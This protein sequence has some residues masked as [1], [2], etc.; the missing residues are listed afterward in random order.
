[1]KIKSIPVGEYQVNCFILP[2]EDRRALIID[3]GKDAPDIL[4]LLK[5]EDLEVAAY[6][7]TH[8]HMDHVS[9]VADIYDAMPAPIA[10]HPADATW[11]FLETNQHPP[12]YGPPRPPAVIERELTDGSR[13][14]ESGLAYEIIATPGHTPGGVCIYFPAEQALFTGDTLFAGSVGRTDLPG[15]DSRILQ[16]SLKKLAA[17]PPETKVFPGHGPATSIGHEKQTNFFL[18]RL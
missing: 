4:K 18:S 11:A 15:G 17:L 8:G 13:W 5:D 16:E 7:L 12:F 9:A 6:L 1:M 14:E 3:P 2:G 10:I